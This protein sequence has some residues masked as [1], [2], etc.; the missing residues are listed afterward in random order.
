M[1]LN[2]GGCLDRVEVLAMA[3]ADRGEV[4]PEMIALTG[5]G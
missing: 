3:G 4:D 1:I 2:A 5:W